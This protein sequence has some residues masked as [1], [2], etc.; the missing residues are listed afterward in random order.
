MIL[1]GLRAIL[2]SQSSVTNI[3]STSGVFVD[4][5]PQNKSLPYVLVDKYTD[6]RN[7]TLGGTGS[8]YTAEIVIQ[9]WERTPTKSKTLADAT[10]AYLQDY[11]GTAGD[12]TID[13][14]IFDDER[15]GSADAEPGTDYTRFV[16]EVEYTIHYTV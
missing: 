8:T 16:T 9:C 15:R 6:D 7:V 4:V 3:V 5:A 1:E 12:V 10:T 2:L 13:A 11:T 14:V